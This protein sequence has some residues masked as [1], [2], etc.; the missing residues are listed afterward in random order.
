MP[1]AR[2][3][4][5]PFCLRPGEAETLLAGHPWARFAVL[6]DSIAEG[7]GDAVDGYG[8]LGWAD[9]GAAA[10]APHRSGFAYL[11]LGR[12][13]PRTAHVRTPQ[14]AAALAWPPH[15]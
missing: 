6:G 5:D 12:P 8:E 4:A 1:P 3:P 15:L 10:L 9:R 7:V 2:M 14:L 13:D 11:N